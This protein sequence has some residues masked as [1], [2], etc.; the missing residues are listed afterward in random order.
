MLITNYL[1]SY[2]LDLERDYYVKSRIGNN[3][4]EPVET[5]RLFSIFRK[6]VFIRT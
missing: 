2:I 6:G 1:F 3:P 4:L 5:P